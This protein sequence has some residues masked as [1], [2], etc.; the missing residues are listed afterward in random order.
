MNSAGRLRCSPASHRRGQTWAWTTTWQ[1]LAGHGDLI[2]DP[3]ALVNHVPPYSQPFGPNAAGT[4]E[5]LRAGADRRAQAIHLQP[6]TI[7]VGEQILPEAFTEDADTS[8][9]SPTR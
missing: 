1:R 3:A 5:L 7:A 8:A 6:S 2:V 4:A 9:I